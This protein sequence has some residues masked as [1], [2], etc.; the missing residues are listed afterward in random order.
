MREK[1]ADEDLAEKEE[2]IFELMGEISQLEGKVKKTNDD[3]NNANRQLQEKMETINSMKIKLKDEEEKSEA[4]E[5]EVLVKEEDNNNNRNNNNNNNSNNNNKEDDDDSALLLQQENAA[6]KL[7]ASTLARENLAVKS[8]LTALTEEHRLSKT[9]LAKLAEE[10]RIATS[11]MENLTKEHRDL[12]AELASIESA[13]SSCTNREAQTDK[14]ISTSEK[15]MTTSV[16][17]LAIALQHFSQ[18]SLLIDQKIASLTNEANN[19]ASNDTSIATSNSTSTGSSAEVAAAQTDRV[20]RS[21]ILIDCETQPSQWADNVVDGE[22]QCILSSDNLVDCEIQCSLASDNLIDCETQCSQWAGNVVDC[23]IQCSLWANDLVSE[24]NS[25]NSILELKNEEMRNLRVEKLLL[26]ENAEEAD[27][28]RK[29]AM[30][31]QQVR[32]LI[33]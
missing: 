32:E 28:E 26:H 11:Q 8:K 6:L 29:R 14:S 13:K 30:G 15:S 31:L 20:L 10:H 4:L 5:S 22:I 7:E 1:R 17:A 19:I 2:M 3:F 21:D 12:V 24:V 27:S 16:V 23:E 9:N 25:L 18:R 33:D